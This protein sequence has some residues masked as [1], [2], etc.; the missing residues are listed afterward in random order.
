MAR[1]PANG[2]GEAGHMPV[3]PNPGD[4]NTAENN[5][6]ESR[7][8]SLLPQTQSRRTSRSRSP[9]VD[10]WGR[11]IAERPKPSYKHEVT[12][13]EIPYGVHTTDYRLQSSDVVPDMSILQFWTTRVSLFIHKENSNRKTGM[14]R[15]HI[16]NSAGDWCGSVTVDTAWLGD[17]SSRTRQE[18]QRCEFIALSDA[19][20]FTEEEMGVWNYFVPAERTDAEWEASYVLLIE[21]DQDRHVWER[22]GLGKVFK[23]AISSEGKWSEIVL[24]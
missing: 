15:C 19:L 6:Y 24:G 22:V 16:G 10:I 23:S 20:S 3:D 7:R 14:T 9:G 12:L 13:P 18:G 17:E 1:S 4:L 8:Q 5:P 2:L 11:W 21:Y